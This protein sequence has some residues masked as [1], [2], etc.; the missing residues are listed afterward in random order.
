MARSIT[1]PRRGFGA[2]GTARG[3]KRDQENLT[4]LRGDFAQG[5]RDQEHV[6]H[7]VSEEDGMPTMG[8]R[9]APSPSG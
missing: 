8:K 5:P 9:P 6:S 7:H 4:P 2:A 1:E 3:Q